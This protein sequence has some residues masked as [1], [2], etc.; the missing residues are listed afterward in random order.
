MGMSDYYDSYVTTREIFLN[1]LKK[2][3]GIEWY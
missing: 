1:K 3:Y 2:E